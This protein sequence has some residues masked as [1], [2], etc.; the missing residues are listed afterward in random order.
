MLI[1][2]NFTHLFLIRKKITNIFKVNQQELGSIKHSFD[3]M[4]AP[5]NAQITEIHKQKQLNIPFFPSRTVLKM[6]APIAQRGAKTQKAIN[7][8]S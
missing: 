1:Q 3:L 7:C 6:V 5:V 2:K 8:S 4:A